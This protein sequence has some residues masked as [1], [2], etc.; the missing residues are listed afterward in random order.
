M[1]SKKRTAAVA[2]ILG[3]IIGIALVTSV[4]GVVYYM[5]YEQADIITTTSHL[6]IRNLNAIKIDGTADTLTV[7]ANI[8]N[9]GTANIDNIYLSEITVSG[10]SITAGTAHTKVKING[11]ADIVVKNGGKFASST[12][13]ASE[14]IEDDIHKVPL[15]GGSSV[16]FQ[17]KIQD[18]DIDPIKISDRLTLQL[19]Y[20]VGNSDTFLTDVYN[21]R[22]RPG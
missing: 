2:N 13:S 19:E 6:E 22:V 15:S 14:L 11:S 20:V 12:K 18:N 9:M 21:T 4:G 10:I 8:R 1:N 17:L 16:A 7:T 5:F 3:L